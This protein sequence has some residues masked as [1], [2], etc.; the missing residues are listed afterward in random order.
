MFSL[1]FTKNWWKNIYNFWREREKTHGLLDWCEMHD[2]AITSSL[3]VQGLLERTNR[4]AIVLST[5]FAKELLNSSTTNTGQ[6]ML[7]QI[8]CSFSWLLKMQATGARAYERFTGMQ[9][10]KI[11]EE[12]LLGGFKK[13]WRRSW[14]AKAM[15]KPCKTEHIKTHCFI[16][17]GCLDNWKPNH[18]G[19][20]WTHSFT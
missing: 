7:P 10:A 19:K 4:A 11:I 20:L 2:A 1:D 6:D 12:E 9:I 16:Q 5:D 18:L 13:H 17:I 14:R 8:L 3:E 15:Q